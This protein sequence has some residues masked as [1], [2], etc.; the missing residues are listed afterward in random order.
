METI[1]SFDNSKIKH[2]KN[3]LG[4]KK[5]RKEFGEYAV[6]GSRWIFDALNTEYAAELFCGVFVKESCVEKFASLIRTAEQKIGAQYIFMVADNVFD[7]VSETEHSQGILANLKIRTVLGAT[8]Q[9]ILYLDRIRDPGNLGTI[10]RTAVAAGF[11]DILLDGCTDIYSPK[12]ARST[13]SALLKI[14]FTMVQD[15]KNPLDSLKTGGYKIL[16]ADMEGENIFTYCKK[17]AKIVLIIGSEA[18]GVHPKLL[19]FADKIVSI[20]MRQ[21]ESLNASVSAG[22]I[23]YQLIQNKG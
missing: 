8:G 7:K 15:G 14:A 13:M 19:K 10:I 6:E 22:I 17:S 9:Y 18:D 1:I 5:C 16:A 12:V 4:D 11:S 21:I 23:M 2:V 20:P 3:L